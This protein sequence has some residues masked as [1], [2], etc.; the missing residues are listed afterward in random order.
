MYLTLT[1]E[2]FTMCNL[3]RKTT[4][5]WDVVDEF[6]VVTMKQ[7]GLTVRHLVGFNYVASYDRSRIGRSI[8]KAM[9]PCEA[10]LPDTYGKKPQELANI[11]NSCIQIVR[12][13]GD[14]PGNATDCVQSPASGSSVQNG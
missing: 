4:I 7:H 9:T 10:A 14:E 13:R 3:F 1:P 5:P 6:F 12:E 11:L 2:G 8:A